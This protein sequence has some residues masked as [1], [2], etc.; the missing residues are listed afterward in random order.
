[1]TIIELCD[2]IEK[3][4]SELSPEAQAAGWRWMETQPQSDSAHVAD[5]RVALQSTREHFK[6]DGPQKLSG[7]WCAEA[8]A[9]VCNCGNSP[10]S[11]ARARY[12]SLCQP[13]TLKVL[14][15]TVRSAQKMAEEINSLI[16]E[17]KNDYYVETPIVFDVSKAGRY[18][19][20]VDYG[21]GSDEPVGAILRA[22][23][24]GEPDELV[25][26]LRRDKKSGQWK[27]DKQ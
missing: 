26:T 11:S 23:E 17:T 27:Q 25:A 2:N 21:S 10:H 4:I 12:L 16:T 20:G 15:E 6:T 24:D 13:A 8:D 14:V 7:V 9:F 18:S 3:A 1:M 22:G 5:Y 19:I